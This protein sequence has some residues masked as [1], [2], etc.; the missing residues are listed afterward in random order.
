M[1]II[2]RYM[3]GLTSFRAVCLLCVPGLVYLASFYLH[4]AILTQTGHGEN[5]IHPDFKVKKFE[6]IRCLSVE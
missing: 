1:S 3:V 2:E 5:Y 4:F 6:K